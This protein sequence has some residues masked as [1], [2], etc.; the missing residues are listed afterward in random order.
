MAYPCPNCGQP[1][2]RAPSAGGWESGG[3]LGW[4]LS[5]AMADFDCARCGKILREEFPPEVQQQMAS[6]SYTIAIIGAVMAM[7]SS[8]VVA[9]IYA[10]KQL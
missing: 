7:A 8:L 2:K 6:G 1:V 10:V 3:L 9:V 5:S 4:L